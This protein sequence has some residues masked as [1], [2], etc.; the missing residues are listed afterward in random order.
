ML[1]QPQARQVRDVAKIDAELSF[2]AAIPQVICGDDVTPSSEL[3]DELLDEREAMVADPG[4][5]DP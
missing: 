5:A 2:V 3:M 1:E 4:T